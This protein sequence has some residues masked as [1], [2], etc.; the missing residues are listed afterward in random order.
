MKKYGLLAH[1]TKY[2]L[3]PK[4][5]TAAFK[6]LG[7][8]NTYGTLDVL[9]ENLETEFPAIKAEYS[10]LS[11]SM[12]HKE[13]ILPLLD[14][15]SLEA[16]AVGAVNT[17]RIENGRAYGFNT[18][19]I[20]VDRSLA[21]IPD[22]VSKKVLINGTGGATRAAIYALNR[23]GI[24]PYVCGRNKEKIE[25]LDQD[26]NIK[27]VDSLSVPGVEV[28]INGTPIGLEKDERYPI[29]DETLGKFK[30]VFD[31]VYGETELLRR[32]TS[33]GVKTINGFEMVLH[34]GYEQFKILTGLDVPKEVMRTAIYS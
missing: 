33:L 25:L 21:E 6:A 9:P 4:M 31:M 3:S 22:L 29:E 2:S 12:P 8:D 11:V 14:T 1:P 5:W 26:F 28:F 30:H 15:I 7:V 27:I 17:V 18:D 20:G 32:S 16:K 13:T 23:I 24:I 10:G 19:W 34:Q